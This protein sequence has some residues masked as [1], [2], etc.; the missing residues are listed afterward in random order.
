[1][2]WI[3][4]ALAVIMLGTIAVMVAALY[5]PECTVGITHK[6]SCEE[7]RRVLLTRSQ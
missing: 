3:Y 5:E 4:R 2:S 6:V 7:M 1:M